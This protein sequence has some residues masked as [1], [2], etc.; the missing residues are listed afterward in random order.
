MSKLEAG[1]MWLGRR[2]PGRH[3][4]GLSDICRHVPFSSGYHLPSGMGRPERTP[5]PCPLLAPRKHGLCMHHSQ[6]H[7]FGIHAKAPG[8]PSL[9]Q[10]DAVW[11]ALMALGSRTALGVWPSHVAPASLH[12]SC[13]SRPLWGPQAH[14]AHIEI[15]ASDLHFS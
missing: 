7:R 1:V 11:L 12:R 14:V 4:T 3:P 10:P 15:H 5:A 13:P 9:S 6:P 2:R 8:P